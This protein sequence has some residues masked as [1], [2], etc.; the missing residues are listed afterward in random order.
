MERYTLLVA[1]MVLVQTTVPALGQV[2]GTILGPGVRQYPIAISGLK[3]LSNGASGPEAKT[4]V[5]ILKRD[6]ELSGR[7][8][9]IPSDSYIEP[10]QTSGITVET[11]NFDNWSVIG[12]LGLIK[13]AIRQEQA[14]VLIEVRLFDV[15]QRR[16]LTGRRFRGGST[17]MRKMAQR[18]ADEVL[19]QITGERGPFNSQIAFLSTRGGRFKDLYVMSPD[20]GDVRRITD[21][22]TLNLS[23]HWA[24]DSRSIVLTSYKTGNPDL[25]SVDLAGQWKRLSSLRGLNLGGRWSPDGTHLAV[26]LE[27]DGNPEIAIL[28]AEGKL[29]RRLTDH[30]AIDVSP[31]WSPDGSRIAFCSSR[32]GSPQIYV[33]SASGG[34]PRRITSTGTYNTS[35]AW[36][37]K[38]DLLA[39]TSRVGGRFQIFTVRLDGSDERQ[40]TQSS[41]DN[42]DPSWAPDG[43]YL[44]FSSTRRGLPRLFMSDAAGLNQV[45]LTVGNGGDTSPSWSRWL[46]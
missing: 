18:F 38:G 5:D 14:G 16:M 45:E 11:I 3:E 9:I 44:V 26:T 25:F 17:E 1:L 37:P 28:D 12:A 23:P 24:P 34:A 35:P 13:G 42:E 30:W 41:G 46:D 8:R 39:Y 40:I 22:N 10:A 31:S 15:S 20:G 7:F 36:S 2:R 19:A 6:L 43:R 27:F 4:F 29:S 33:M 21:D 32:S